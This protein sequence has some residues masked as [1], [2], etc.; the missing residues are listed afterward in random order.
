MTDEPLVNPTRR[1][2]C[3]I[4]G[5]FFRT[6]DP[7]YKDGALSGSRAPGRYSRGNQKTLYLSASRAGTEAAMIAHQNCE[8]R[9]QCTLRFHV[10]AE[11]IFD[12]RDEQALHDVRVAAGDP[13]VNWQEVVAKGQEPLS[14]RVRDWVEAQ[15]A[16]GLIDP[17]RRAPGLWHLV[18]FQW[19]VLGS[20]IVSP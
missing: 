17:S 10:Q 5:S 6:V 9:P 7:R 2:L 18:L 19:R 15:G 16:M 20:A 12:L 13:F 8:T 11:N 4:S 3:S 1:H 14:W